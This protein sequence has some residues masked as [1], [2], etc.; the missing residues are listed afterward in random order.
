[1]S[2]EAYGVTVVSVRD[3]RSGRV[4]S[5]PTAS[6][7]EKAIA[8]VIADDAEEAE[9]L[10]RHIRTDTKTPM[11]KHEQN[12]NQEQT[13]KNEDITSLPSVPSGLKNHIVIICQSTKGIGNFILPLRQREKT[14]GKNMLFVHI[15]CLS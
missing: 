9:Q 11:F 7:P 6:L 2:Y 14:L 10:G 15:W 5:D 4:L 12:E 1:M 13:M 8:L 3:N